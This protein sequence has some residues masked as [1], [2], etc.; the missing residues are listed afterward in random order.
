M[1]PPRVLAS[2]PGN[3]ASAKDG[4][5]SHYIVKYDIVYAMTSRPAQKLIC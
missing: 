5:K 1:M 3:L 2:G 4:I